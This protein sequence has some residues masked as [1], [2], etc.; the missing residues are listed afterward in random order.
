[1]K[2]KQVERV[3]IGMFYFSI[4]RAYIFG[5]PIKR[6]IR[7]NH[8]LVLWESLCLLGGG[9]TGGTPGLAEIAIRS[10]VFWK[11]TSACQAGGSYISHGQRGSHPDSFPPFLQPDDHWSPVSGYPRC[12]VSSPCCLCNELVHLKTKVLYLCRV[13][14]S[15]EVRLS[16][17]VWIP[18]ISSFFILQTHLILTNWPHNR[19]KLVHNRSGHCESSL[20]CVTTLYG[21]SK[22]RALLACSSSN[23]TTL[24]NS[25]P[26]T[27][28][29]LSDGCVAQTLLEE[30]M[31]DRFIDQWIWCHCKMPDPPRGGLSANSS[32]QHN[33]PH[34]PV[35]Y[36]VLKY[37]YVSPYVLRGT[38]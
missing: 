33:V 2:H 11:V 10:R 26:F 14:S 35:T 18:Y 25:R 15:P 32:V 28:L 4:G 30:A 13:S 16:N 1:M 21:V 38:Y 22:R 23:V 31:L 9:N 20:P 37:T 34:V 17:V 7:D 3:E 5:L 12:Q 19:Y 6:C 24:C 8:D 36:T 29:K 27:I